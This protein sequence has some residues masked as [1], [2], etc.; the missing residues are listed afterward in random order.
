M[1]SP[2]R[3]S[4]GKLLGEGQESCIFQSD[5]ERLV[6]SVF[7]K[8]PSEAEIKKLEAMNKI[9]LEKDPEQQFF[10]SAGTIHTATI[11]RFKEL[12]PYIRLSLCSGGHSE[13][14][15]FGMLPKLTPFVKNTHNLSHILRGLEL[16]HSSKSDSVVHGDI[17]IENVMMHK[18]NAVLIDFGQSKIWSGS[19][20]PG[21]SRSIDRDLEYFK[22]MAEDEPGR[23]SKRRFTQLP[24]DDN[25]DDNT[26]GI[27]RSLF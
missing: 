4:A 3:S 14:V 18:H 20:S 16:L 11:E 22:K 17:K 10:V 8:R 21:D 9:L 7:K 1:A 12:F 25:K 6:I 23:P 24:E 27:S 5:N 26:V 15:S 13:T 2:P 19:E